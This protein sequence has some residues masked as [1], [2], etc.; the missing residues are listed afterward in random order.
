MY[1]SVHRSRMCGLG[2][3]DP[4]HRMP[5]TVR[6]DGTRRRALLQLGCQTYAL[7]HHHD[8]RPSAGPRPGPERP[9]P[10]DAKDCQ[11]GCGAARDRDRL[12]EDSAE[13]VGPVHVP[14]LCHFRKMVSICIA[15][16]DCSAWHYFEHRKKRPVSIL[17]ILDDASLS[18]GTSSRRLTSSANSCRHLEPCHLRYQ[19]LLRYRSLRNRRLLQHRIYNLR[20][21][22][23]CFDIEVD[24]KPLISKKLRYQGLNLRYR[25]QIS[26]LFDIEV[27]CFDIGERCIRYRS[28]NF[29]YRALHRR[30]LI[31]K[32]LIFDI[33]VL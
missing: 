9:G 30:H 1:T 17:D 11:C 16:A 6:P 13:E 22:S 27:D 12:G 25:V 23:I 7:H 28:S 15:F 19:R 5:V 8:S 2:D 3:A 24:K 10:G 31:S 29:V 33:E 4:S 14:V 21:P 32:I 20:Y 18:V 26:K